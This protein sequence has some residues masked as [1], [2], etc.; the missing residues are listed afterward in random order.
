[1]IWFINA[2]EYLEEDLWPIQPAEVARKQKVILAHAY[3][4]TPRE[5]L[6]E[7]MARLKTVS[8]DAKACLIEEITELHICDRKMLTS[9]ARV[10]LDY[11]SGW[12]RRR[13]PFP[14]WRAQLK[15]KDKKR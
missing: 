2:L 11:I 14:E 6:G 8:P 4:L 13:K 9:P 3:F 15:W 12:R 7:V 5:F 1:M 10:A